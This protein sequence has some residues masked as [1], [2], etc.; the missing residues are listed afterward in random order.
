MNT[1]PK[2]PA[3][4]VTAALAA[5]PDSSAAE[6]AEAAGIGGAT[7]TSAFRFRHHLQSSNAAAASTTAP[8]S[9]QSHAQPLGIS[10]GGLMSR[11]SL[12]FVATT[13]AV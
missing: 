9:H 8:S 5:H 7:A 12:A 6:L 3:E 11:R 4:A 10:T 2:T 13:D 1:T